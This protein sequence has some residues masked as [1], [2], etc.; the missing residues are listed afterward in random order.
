MP[1][2]TDTFPTAP[3]FPIGHEDVPLGDDL[4]AVIASYIPDLVTELNTIMDHE[5]NIEIGATKGIKWDGT[6]RI[7]LWGGEIYFTALNIVNNLHTVN[8]TISTLNC[9][10]LSPLSNLIVESFLAVTGT[11][12]VDDYVERDVQ[13]FTQA[14]EPG[15]PADNHAVFWISNGTGYGD[16]GDF[17]CKITE[18]GGTTSFTISDYSV[19]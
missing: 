16:A 15:D 19:L 4:Y 10:D 6:E 13:T 5:G 7:S 18:G 8:A 14:A 3:G 11:V 9:N 12:T 2:P 1:Y 17:C